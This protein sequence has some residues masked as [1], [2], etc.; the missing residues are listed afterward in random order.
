MQIIIPMSGFGERFRRAGYQTPKPLIE[1]E[2]K[3]IIAH[4]IDMFPGETDFTFICNEDHLNEPAFQMKKILNDLCPTGRI[5][6]IPSHK[7]GP[8]YAVL[9]AADQINLNKPTIVNYCDF[10]CYWDWLHFK[11]WVEANQ[12]MG[13]VPAYK[14][15][16]PHTLGTTNYAYM[17]E[18]DGWMLDIQEKQPYT[19]NRMNE[20]ASSGTYYFVN[21][22]L[23][24]DA[25]K[26]TI[27]ENLHINNEYYVSLAYKILLAK[28]NAV[29]IYDLQHFMQWGTP[30]DVAEYQNW[31]NIFH[32]LHQPANNIKT[33]SGTVIIP[34]AGLGKRFSDEG[35][36]ITKPLIPVSGHPMVLQAVH[37]LPVAE[38]YIFI[39]RSDMP[40]LT[41]ISHTLQKTYSNVSIK[42]VPHVTEGQA[43][44][45]LIGLDDQSDTPEPIIFGACDN[46]AL[47]DNNKLDTLLKDASIDVI[48]WGVRGHVNAIRNPQMYGWIDAQHNKIH[49]ISVKTPLQSPQTD[50]IVL[51]TFIFKRASDYRRCVERMIQRNC[52]INGEFYID[53]C[54]NDAIELGLNC[55][56]FE[57]DHYISWGTPNDLRTFEY[58][59][60]CF[61][62]WPSHSYQLALD[63]RVNQ[64][65]CDMLKKQY[66][67]TVPL[68]LEPTE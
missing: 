21:G 17:R 68:L 67:T 14:G 55:V 51:G 2:G 34:M 40:G 54:I 9:Q 60:S 29:A 33:A 30:D 38:K 22:Q 57:V 15:F 13:A 10:T 37:D 31:S 52:R 20:Y 7:L 5:I 1:I 8:V 28:N 58:W 50:H 47:Y 49:H 23:M 27:Q 56:L 63:N 48:V 25:F 35:Y 39:L 12:C 64:H 11:A 42:T 6:S 24:L 3:P 62:K 43:C 66:E 61:H 41:E 45:A 53:T 4:V 44:T 19:D 59:Q 65:H 32:R 26:Q 36:T 16:H 18:K 46:G